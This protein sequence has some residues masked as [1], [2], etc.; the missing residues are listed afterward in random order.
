MTP[1][2]KEQTDL[3]PY[4]PALTGSYNSFWE[5]MNMITYPS[6]KVAAMHIAPVFLDT[7]ATVEKACS[8]IEEAARNGARLIAFSETF[9]PA[10][11]IWCALRAPLYNHEFFKT[12][13]A[14]ALKMQGPEL[15]RI[16]D[17]TRKHGVFVSLGFNEG[18]DASVGCIWNSNVL[19]DEKGR[20]INHHRKMVP[21]FWEKLIWANGDGAGLRVCDTEIGKIGMLICGENTNPL[22]RFALMAQGEQIHVSSFPPVWP[23][24]DP[25][26]DGHYDVG[27]AIRIRTGNHSF[28]G[29]LFNV[30]ASGYLDRRSRD[31]LAQN[32]REIARILDNSPRGIS[33]VIGPG[34]EPI[35]DVLCE[36]E[37]ILYADV[38]LA[39]CV[40]PKEL[41]DLVGY[42]NRFDIFKLTVNRSANR[43][44]SFEEPADK[45]PDPL[46]SGITITSD[47]KTMRGQSADADRTR[48]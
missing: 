28:E 7:D 39:N 35:S 16:C 8:M 31:M 14:N 9:I 21:T 45:G 46:P 40:E 36:E 15:A 2:R 20:V 10:F 17:V 6:F 5:R 34:G 4:F 32:D 26:D 48:V 18:T 11:P 42:Y 38:N 25:K 33:M 1:T 23:A 22:A 27:A 43:P 3:D 47:G 44:I 30:V 12:L 19:I 24:R 41:H 37:G 13:A 29:K